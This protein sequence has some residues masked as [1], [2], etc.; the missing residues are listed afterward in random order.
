MCQGRYLHKTVILWPKSL[1]EGLT[2]HQMPTSQKYQ[3]LF[4]DMLRYLANNNP[5]D[6]PN[7]QCG[8]ML[9]NCCREHRHHYQEDFYAFLKTK[10]KKYPKSWPNIY[11][12]GLFD[13][14][15]DHTLQMSSLSKR[16]M[17]NYALCKTI[18]PSI[19]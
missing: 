18:V 9:L 5:R 19:N 8:I 2:R 4:I 7:T 13:P 16:R 10:S 6:F 15:L 1:L 17:E 12:E 3:G 14:E 11:Q